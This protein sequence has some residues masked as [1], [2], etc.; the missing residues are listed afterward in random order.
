MKKVDLQVSGMTCSSCEVLIERGLKKVPGVHNVQVSRAKEKAIVHC[1]DAVQLDQLQAAVAEKGYSLS[2]LPS[3]S[4]SN[5]SPEHVLK[6]P[7]IVA[8]SSK[9]KEIGAVF[10]AMVGAYLLLRQF[11]IL[12]KGIGVTDNMSYGFVFL[13]GLVAA[14]STCLAVAGGLLLAISQKYNEAHPNLTGAQ[15][16]KHH[17]SFNV[18]RI[19]SYT[20]LGGAI[21]AL[22][23]VISISSQVNGM[24]TILAGVLMIIIGMQLLQIFPWLN[25]IQVKMPKFIAHRIYDASSNGEQSEPTRLSSF[26]FGGSTFFLPCG[27]TQALQL[28]VL[29]TGNM[30][31]GA[32]TMLAFSLG[33]LPALA[34]IGAF[35]SFAKGNAQRYFTTFSAVLVIILGA[36]AM[37][38]GLTLIQLGDSNS[39]ALNGPIADVVDGQIQTINMEVRGLDYYPDSFQLQKGVPVQWNIDGRKATGCAK[40]IAAPALGISERLLSDRITT[41]TFTPTQA[42]R[43]TFSC[44][45]GMAGPGTFEVI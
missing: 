36:L 8:N 32:L 28:Y 24:I 4:S 33:T 9:Y 19:I 12:P 41:V 38:S 45:M 23:S 34:G 5:A 22:G 3:V 30:V 37:P 10:I 21:G 6:T 2:E 14:T 43:I 42:G 7:F 44:S 15:K 11:D 20:V 35:T 16:F 39:A 13:I 17:L 40:V 18:G 1:D 31:I 27:F 29:G 25:K 26:L